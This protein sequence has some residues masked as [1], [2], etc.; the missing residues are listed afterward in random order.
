MLLVEVKQ[1][2]FP[3]IY[4]SPLFT[5]SPFRPSLSKEFS[6]I[7]DFS[8]PYWKTAASLKLTNFICLTDQLKKSASVPSKFG[9]ILQLL[10]ASMYPPKLRIYTF[11]GLMDNWRSFLKLASETF[12]WADLHANDEPVHLLHPSI[13]CAWSSYNLLDYSIELQQSCLM[14]CHCLA[15][16]E[17]FELKGELSAHHM[18]MTIYPEG[19]PSRCCHTDQHWD[20]NT[21]SQISQE[22]AWKDSL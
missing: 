14:G 2:S 22:A 6:Y 10:Y 19:C 3:E 4:I 9:D 5:S 17:D 21:L 20:E 12:L 13:V 11:S 16:L 15:L 7:T 1:Y 18:Q 8:W